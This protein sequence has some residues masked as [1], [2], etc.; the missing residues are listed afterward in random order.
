MV[1]FSGSFQGFALD[2]FRPSYSRTWSHEKA[3]EGT[4]NMKNVGKEQG[5]ELSFIC[6]IVI[7]K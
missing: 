3:D 7:L 1:L 6:P 5:T 2:N 4:I